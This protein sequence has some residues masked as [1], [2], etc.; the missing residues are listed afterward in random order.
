MVGV[1]Q[2]YVLFSCKGTRYFYKLLCTATEDFLHFIVLSETTGYLLE[3]LF[4]K[5]PYG[6][7]L[8]VLVLPIIF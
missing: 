1:I 8:P 3:V 7:Y 4:S 6:I 5:S 2:S